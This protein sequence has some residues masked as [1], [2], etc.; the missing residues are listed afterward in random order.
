MQKLIWENNLLEAE[1]HKKVF[2]WYFSAI[3]ISIYMQR[4]YQDIDHRVRMN[5][6]L[7]FKL[8]QELKI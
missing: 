7:M 6:L 1:K 4:Y 3:Q 8:N 2:C 5:L